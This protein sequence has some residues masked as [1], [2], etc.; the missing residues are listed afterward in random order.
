VIVQLFSV[1]VTPRKT[2]Y[3]NLLASRTSRAQESKLLFFPDVG[4]L[5]PA[6][7]VR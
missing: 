7:C 4:N 6:E 5:C 1:A 2:L 3:A